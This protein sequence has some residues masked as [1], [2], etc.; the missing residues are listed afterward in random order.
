M[1]VL[2][3]SES[4]GLFIGR[5]EDRVAQTP[6]LSAQIGIVPMSVGVRETCS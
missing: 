4:D 2:L 6:I 5:R 3:V 1:G